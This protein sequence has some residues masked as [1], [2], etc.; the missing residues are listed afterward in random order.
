MMSIN[1][2]KSNEIKEKIHTI[3]PNITDE[4]LGLLYEYF[5]AKYL[6]TITESLKDKMLQQKIKEIT[7]DNLITK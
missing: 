2:E 1:L 4:L 5:T 7:V 3:N 6:F